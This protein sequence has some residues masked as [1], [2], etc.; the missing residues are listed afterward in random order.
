[1]GTIAVAIALIS[2]YVEPL[3]ELY[4]GE[5]IPKQGETG[6]SEQPRY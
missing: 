6:L 1:M 5:K 2:E 4:Y 3:N